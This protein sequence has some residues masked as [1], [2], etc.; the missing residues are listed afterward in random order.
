MVVRNQETVKK[1]VKATLAALPMASP[2]DI[3]YLVNYTLPKIP[4]KLDRNN[5]G[6]LIIYPQT[7]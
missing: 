1:Q 6:S 2:I 5:K 4:G 7:K 3:G